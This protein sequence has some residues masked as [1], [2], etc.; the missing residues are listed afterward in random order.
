MCVLGVV[1]NSTSSKNLL[2][3]EFITIIEDE[4]MDDLNYI[5]TKMDENRN[6][7]ILMRKEIRKYAEDNFSWTHFITNYIYNISNIG[8]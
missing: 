1:I 6:K 5:Q 3:N 7:S 4:K 2:L 8:I